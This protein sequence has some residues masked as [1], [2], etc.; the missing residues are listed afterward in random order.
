MLIPIF[1]PGLRKLSGEETLAYARIR[2]ID[3]DFK[4]TNRQRTVLNAIFNQMKGLSITELYKLVEKSLP[5]VTTDMTDS[6]ILSY[7]LDLAP[8]MSQLDVVSQRIP[9]DGGYAFASI[10]RKSVLYLNSQ[11]LEKNKQLLLET[12]GG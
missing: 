9:M 6:E 12:I 5:L 3:N 4:R 1:S 11:N 10:D 7:I 8:I 2:A